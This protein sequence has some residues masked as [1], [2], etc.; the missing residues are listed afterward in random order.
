[1]HVTNLFCIQ[2]W[3]YICL[4]MNLLHKYKMPLNEIYTVYRKYEYGEYLWYNVV[5]KSSPVLKVR[6]NI[7]RYKLSCSLA[8]YQ[9]S[10]SMIVLKSDT[11][12]VA[13]RG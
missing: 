11:L 2:E 7:A 3:V 12:I 5:V 6:Y 1:M 4:K 10:C 9:E 13:D 8:N